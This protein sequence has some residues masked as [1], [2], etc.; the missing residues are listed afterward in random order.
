MQNGR[1]VTPASALRFSTWA[2]QVL[3]RVCA[4]KEMQI[5]FGNDN[6]KA[7]IPLRAEL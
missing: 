2:D 4:P 6:R 5:P 1:A 3:E 7:D